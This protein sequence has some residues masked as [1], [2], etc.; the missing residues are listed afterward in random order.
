MKYSVAFG[1]SVAAA[2]DLRIPSCPMSGFVP[3]GVAEV[4]NLP[5]NETPV[6]Y[7]AIG[8]YPEDESKALPYPK[9][10]FP[11]NDIVRNID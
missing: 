5:E 4:L 10:R 2:A 8:H 9:F 1:V 11:I 3:S 6:A 7:L